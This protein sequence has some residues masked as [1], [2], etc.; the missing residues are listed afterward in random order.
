[1]ETNEQTFRHSFGKLALMSL[2]VLFLGYAAFAIG[3]RDYFLMAVAGLAFIIVLFYATSSVRISDEG[4]TTSRLLGSKSLRWSEVASV[5]TRGPALRLHNRDGDLTLSIDSQLDG[6]K[7]ILDIVFSRRPD[8]LDSSENNVMSRNWL[9]DL[10][11]LGFGLFILAIAIFLFFMFDES[12]KLLSVIFLALGVYVIVG[13]FLSPK[14]LTLESKNLVMGY[15]FKEV[16]HSVDDINSISLEKRRTRNG[17]IYFVQINLASGK[18]IK[19]PAFKQ[20][21]PLTYQILKKW[22]QKASRFA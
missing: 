1:M 22:H 17:Y 13:W 12:D 18:K 19:L 14:S 9:N 5:S 16:S 21:A 4:I 7:E 10:L 6:Y 2:G 3:E 20:G 11:F 8:L 15:L